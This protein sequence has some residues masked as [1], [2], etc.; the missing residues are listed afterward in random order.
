MSRCDAFTSS[1]WTAPVRLGVLLLLSWAGCAADG[2]PSYP[3][4]AP[5]ERAPLTAACDDID[6]LRCLLPWP[7]NTFARA[8]PESP[9]GLRVAVETG[10]VARDDDPSTINLADGFSRVSPVMTGFSSALGDPD[11]AIR[12]ILA[13]HD[14]PR[15]GETVPLRL[16]VVEDRGPESL[17]V[18]YPLEPLEANA[19]YV[20]V[21]L[22]Q[23][24][25]AEGEPL[26][27]SRS[28]LVALGLV[29]PA[30][31]A[32][33]RLA[34]YHGPTRA[35]LDAAGIGAE[36]V[37]VVWDF[38]TRTAA[39]P[40]RWLEHMR[41][42]SEAAV[43]SGEVRVVIDQV[44]APGAENAVAVVEGRLIGLPRYC[45]D[46]GLVLDESALPRSAGEGEAPFRV[47]IPQGEG[48]YPVVMYGHGTG[49][50]FHDS[51]FDEVLA[52][53]GLAKVGLHL[54]GW[55]EDEVPETF[56]GFQQWLRGTFRSTSR[57]LQA[58]ADGMA[59]QRALSGALGEALAAETLGG[60]PNPAAGRRPE[61]DRVLWTGGSLGGVMGLVYA[62]AQPEL[63]A[64]VLNVPG[65]AWTH[66]MPDSFDWN[67]LEVLFGSASGGPIDMVRAA[68]VAQINWDPV[69]G[70]SW[71]DVWA[72][73]SAPLLIQESMGDPILP[74][75]GSEMVAVSV[76]AAQVGVVLEPISGLEARDVVVGGSGI[77]QFRV[78]DGSEPLEIHGFGA[79]GS[80]AGVAA[81]EQITAFLR[82]VLAGEPRIEAPT[83][84]T[85]G[86]ADGSCDFSDL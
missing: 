29:E 81:R 79:R 80:P 48:D 59:I 4:R 76:G 3:E 41:A 49:G 13:Q 14:H 65:A 63:E 85:E 74:N 69:D 82:S 20:A 2:V 56:L 45:D 38:T 8:D 61:T 1:W 60:Q 11:G 78:P 32:E 6:P 77:T 33:A 55:T 7:S 51:S 5:G 62:G 19:D 70:A 72:E 86:T 30:D 15:A 53:L 84:C 43:E 26:E 35:A 54:Y 21:V 23:L 83:A 50:S 37:V 64:G 28:I 27:P 34:A 52:G 22:D 17:L 47:V 18:A 44:E 36:S 24:T 39:D 31:E 68:S 66:W 75:A 58:L 10:S 46:A 25:T 67:L 9:T 71:T 42:C 57:L 12:L 40:R 73:R 16:R